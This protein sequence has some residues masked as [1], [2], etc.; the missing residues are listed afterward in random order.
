MGK[1]DGLQAHIEMKLSEER[2]KE[3]EEPHGSMR[4]AQPWTNALQLKSFCF[5]DGPGSLAQ[6]P[7]CLF[8]VIISKELSSIHHFS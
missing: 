8:P 2:L 3:T 7:T 6:N 5:K 1:P 4:V